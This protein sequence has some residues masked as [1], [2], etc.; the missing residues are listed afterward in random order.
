MNEIIVVNY[1]YGD[2]RIPT[3]RMVGDLCEIFYSKK[4]SFR[5]LSSKSLYKK[6]NNNEINSKFEKFIIR[7]STFS[8]FQFVNKLLFTFAFITHLLKNNYK[9][10]LL[11]TDPPLMIFFLPLIKKLKPNIEIIYWTMDLYPEALFASK[12][13]PFNLKFVN[14][15]FIWF[16]D[17]SLKNINK[18]VNLSYCQNN[19]FSKY[20]NT[21]HII[22]K[23]IYPW[24][25]RNMKINKHKL[26]EF[27]K[28]YPYLNKKVF[29]YAGNLGRAHSIKTLISFINYC[30]RHSKDDF[31]FLFACTGYKKKTIEYN[32]SNNRNVIIQDYFSLEETAYLFNSIYCH[33]ITLDDDWEG[34]VLPSKFFGIFKSN[35]PSLYIG[36]QKSDIAKLIKRNN[37]GV[38]FENGEN[39]INIYNSLKLLPKKINIM[40]ETFD[41]NPEKFVNFIFE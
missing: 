36:P 24:D 8:N 12:I 19:L 20:K 2:N 6:L 34:I 33:I 14:K 21:K 26:N 18:M 27:K 38:A 4:I 30:D 29:L 32:L 9:K 15:L 16:K 37:L 22:T 17:I 31:L 39:P 5:V 41:K 7:S 35:K 11:L 3:A 13:F 10:C 28:K 25:L 23:I 40:T 1:F